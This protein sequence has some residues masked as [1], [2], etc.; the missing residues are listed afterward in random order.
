MPPSP[1]VLPHILHSEFPGEIPSSLENITA[2][3]LRRLGGPWLNNAQLKLNRDALREALHSA[4]TSPEI[5]RQVYVRLLPHERSVLEAYCRYGGLVGGD[6]ILHD[7]TARRLLEVVETKHSEFYTSLSWKYNSFETLTRNGI[8]L[9][10]SPDHRYSDQTLFFGR[11]GPTSGIPR[12]GVQAGV[13]ALVKPAGPPEWSIPPARE[14][15]HSITRRSPAEV[16]LDLSRVY[17]WLVSRGSVKLRRNGMISA[18]ALKALAKGV[19]LA[20]DKVFF[21]PDPNGLFF[22]LLRNAGAIRIEGEEALP[23]PG[24]ASRLF[25]HSG[26]WQ[27]HTWARG[28]LVSRGWN[29]AEGVPGAWDEG[30]GRRDILVAREVLA[31]ALASLVHTG[32][33]WYDLATFLDGLHVLGKHKYSGFLASPKGW[34]PAFPE[35]PNKGAETPQERLRAGWFSSAG[36]W[37][38]NA[39][40]VTLVAL[41]LVERAWLGTGDAARPAFRL[42]DSGRAVFGAPEIP[43]P[44]EPE[45]APCLLV[46][47][48][49]DLIVYL[50]Q[51]TTQAAAFLG[52]VAEA[53]SDCSGPIQTL[54]ITR[55]RF[56]ESQ[57]SG[58]S[59]AE[60]V[61]FLKEQNRREL[62]ANVLRSLADWAGK[63]EGMTLSSGLT[64]LGFPSTADR[65][66]YHEQHPKAGTPCGERFILVRGVIDLKALSRS[67]MRS[68]HILSLRRCL[69]LNE[70]GYIQLQLP[71][72]II[73]TTRLRR[74]ARPTSEG[75]K[76]SADSIQSAVSRGIKPGLIR[77]WLDD[78]LAHPAPRLMEIA[79]EAWSNPGKTPPLALAEAV[80][81]YVP[82]DDQFHVFRSSPRLQPYLL[83]S[84]G[85]QWLLVKPECRKA[86]ASALQELGFQPET[87]LKPEALA[88]IHQMEGSTPADS[89]KSH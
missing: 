21:L 38:A 58:V 5:A 89:R 85:R 18:S 14:I 68:D 34:K 40:T 26:P 22:E 30:V 41:G 42:T 46:Q 69:R 86:L 87:S 79:I 63:R 59:L 66:V 82:D 37:H 32:D 75:W 35:T 15:P 76:L 12:L 72:D 51:A 62:P 73:Q 64:L 19:P 65:D 88:G 53:G 2:S 67:A 80:L 13:A 39:L 20:Q 11:I 70:E 48:N 60:I 3:D 4:F 84:P 1:E 27:A 43:P 61:D 44:A 36:T 83:G 8:L 29:D 56:Y 24:G 28:W 78:H 45:R 33:H 31:W 50:D 9:H 74:I 16:A 77:R 47:P 7:L 81:L 52:R 57:E 10:D 25:G 71:L 54:R 55:T 49:F 17:A 6:V 23:D